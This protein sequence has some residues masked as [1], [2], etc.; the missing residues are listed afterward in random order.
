MA[1]SES[2][3][4]VNTYSEAFKQFICA[5]WAPYP[6]ELPAPLPA[7]AWAAKRRAALSALFPGERLVLAAGGLKARNND[8]D[9]RFRPDSA[10]AH[11]TGLGTDREPNAVLV[12]EPTG[13]SGHTATLY[14]HPRV[15]RT[16]PELYSSAH[17]G[18]MW[19]GQ[20][21]SLDEMSA[22]A[23]LP[24]AVIET[25]ADVLRATPKPTAVLREAD[26]EVAALVDDVRGGPDDD[27]D[28]ALKVA[29]S[30]LRLIKDE[31]ELAELRKAC[32]LT[33]EAFEA[34]VRELGQAQA[35]GRGERW[36]EGVFG[37]HARH[38][39]NAVGYDTIAAAGDHACTLHWIR[40]DGDVRGGDLLL[41]DAGIEVDSL[42]TAD[43]T[44]TL[45]VSGKFSPAQ[46]KVYDAVRAA[47]QAGFDAAK[48][49]AHYMDVHKAA[50]KVLAETFEAW[51]ILPVPAAQ[52]LGEDGGE[53]RRWMVHNTSH[54]LG[55]DVHDCAHALREN[56]RDGVLKPGMVLTVEPGAYFKSTDL[57]VPEELRGIG[58]RI[59][60]DIVITE[61]GCEILSD[62]LPRDADDVEAWM[63]VVRRPAEGRTP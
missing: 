54:M 26:P 4:R 19:V 24:C 56:Y 58:V 40:N 62:A 16:D 29:A 57:A 11:L 10:F 42:Y 12:L 5:D 39:G 44:R 63:A 15:P 30:E 9:Y 38:A 22:L 18:E 32:D 47:Q 17:F 21:M 45:P 28:D 43:I 1:K 49:G 34:V 23:A 60:D 20:R 61:T 41:M 59:E 27:R 36:V 50:V 37:L 51:G 2:A 14:F 7:T 35:A 3:N 6:A 53:W 33:A 48:P 8:C 13:Q 52:S 46:R 55:L 25:L 31:F